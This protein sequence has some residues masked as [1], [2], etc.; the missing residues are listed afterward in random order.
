VIRKSLENVWRTNGIPRNFV[1]SMKM[2]RVLIS[3]RKTFFD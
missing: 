2:G 3:L 1:N